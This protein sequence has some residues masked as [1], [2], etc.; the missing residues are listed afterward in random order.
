MKLVSK[1]PVGEGMYIFCSCPSTQE[2]YSTPP[3]F[4]CAGSGKE[5]TNAAFFDQPMDF[6]E[7]NRQTLDFIYDNNLISRV[8]FLRDA[9]GILAK[10]KIYGGVEE[11]IEPHFFQGTTDE[12]GFSRLPWAEKEMRFLL[13]KKR[14]VQNPLNIDRAI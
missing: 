12:K 4:P 1:L 6:I 3:K 7:Q 14:E 13:K 11:I 5:K 8:E 10:G 9:P 2:V